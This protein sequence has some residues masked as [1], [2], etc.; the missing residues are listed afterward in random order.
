MIF[1]VKFWGYLECKYFK[2]SSS[3]FWRMD[4]QTVTIVAVGNWQSGGFEMDKHL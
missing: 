4:K 3:T 2:G 1:V